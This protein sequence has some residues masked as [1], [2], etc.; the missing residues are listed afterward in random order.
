MSRV[1]EPRT[2]QEETF[3]APRKTCPEKVAFA[4]D[5]K[6]QQRRGFDNKAQ[7]CCFGQGANGWSAR[8]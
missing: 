5:R 8:A 2:I 1:P 3:H 6:Y 4:N 7:P